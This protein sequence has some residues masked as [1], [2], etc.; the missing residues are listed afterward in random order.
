MTNIRGGRHECWDRLVFDLA[1]PAVPF[2]GQAVGYSVRYVP[3][4]TDD[5]TGD[6]V[7]LAGGRLPAGHGPRQRL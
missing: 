5:G 4:V 7:P 1:A 2:P 3:V 6:P